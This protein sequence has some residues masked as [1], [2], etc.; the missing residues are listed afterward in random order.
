MCEVVLHLFKSSN[1]FSLVIIINIYESLAESRLTG[2][3]AVFHWG[4]GGRGGDWERQG[5]NE[6]LRDCVCVDA[7]EGM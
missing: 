6:G 7:W 3:F 4:E 5:G 1:S 2:Q